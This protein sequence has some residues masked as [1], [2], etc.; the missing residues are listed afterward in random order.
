M[1]GF[2]G[3]QKDPN[4]AYIE[5]TKTKTG[6][7][8]S[9][10]KETKEEDGTTTE[11]LIAFIGEPDDIYEATITPYNCDFEHWL[12]TGPTVDGT[13]NKTGDVSLQ[14]L[15]DVYLKG[16][17]SY[18]YSGKMN[19]SWRLDYV[20]KYPGYCNNYPEYSQSPD[21]TPDL[22]FNPDMKGH[23][24]CTTV[25][26]TAA[27]A[28][29][30]ILGDGVARIICKDY[31]AWGKLSAVITLDKSAPINAVSYAEPGKQYVT[32]PLDKDENKIADVWEK[33]NNKEKHLLTWDEDAEPTKQ[34]DNGDGYTLFE[35]YR[36][37]AV[38]INADEQKQISEREDFLRTDPNKKDAFVYDKDT[39]F[40]TYYEP[41]N[42]SKLEWHYLSADMK[43]LY[44]DDIK[45][46]RPL[47]RWVNF[48]KVA[49]YFYSEQY[50]LVLTSS[51]NV[52]K[53]DTLAT[54]ISFTSSEWQYALDVNANVTSSNEVINQVTKENNGGVDVFKSPMK[55]HIKIEIL[56]TGIAKKCAYIKE[57]SGEEAFQKAKAA[58]T[59]STVIH[60]IG[61]CIGICHHKPTADC[62]P[63]NCVMRYLTSTQL[64]SAFLSVRR[65]AYCYPGETGPNYIHIPRTGVTPPGEKDYI[66]Q[67]AGSSSSDNCYGKITV[68]SKPGE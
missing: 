21:I 35:E 53:Y 25:N 44:Y 68:K 47:N 62:G 20:T 54:G 29:N 27:T 67:P 23:A 43:Q 46:R 37:F 18:K 50:A 7:R 56:A 59:G 45:I 49:D 9:Y 3:M 28:E 33:D 11:D 58:S 61:H 17:P 1:Y 60:E 30:I 4:T 5:L 31:A 63:E 41:Y 14:F 66:E 55:T 48:N 36:G 26:N 64:K 34:R 22:I 32:I 51:T 65:T 16:H 42:P 24:G 40:Q 12:P 13:T 10:S 6:Y 2:S 8:I 57:H 15:V 52:Y 39:L 38:H 19:V